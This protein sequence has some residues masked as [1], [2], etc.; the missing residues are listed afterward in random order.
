MSFRESLYIKYKKYKILSIY[1][2]RSFFKR[3]MGGISLLLFF[4]SAV[5]FLAIL[6]PSFRQ[7][8]HD[9]K[10]ISSAPYELHITGRIF[11]QAKGSSGE[12]IIRP[13]TG[14][15]IESGGFNTT[16]DLTGSYN[17]EF[18]SRRLEDVPL[19]FRHGDR[20]AVKRINFSNGD[21]KVQEDFIFK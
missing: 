15:T 6:L 4:I 12:I 5:L 7:H 8:I 21:Y 3:F 17:L 19:I 20:E 1:Y 14:A 13:L 9:S 18:I 2:T 11:E 10:L 16:S